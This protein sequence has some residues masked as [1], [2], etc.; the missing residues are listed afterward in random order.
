MPTQAEIIEQLT[1]VIEMRVSQWGE[2][3]PEL[4]RQS[5]DVVLNLTAD[6]DT[7]ADGKIKPT[8]KNIKIIS[9]IKDELNR[10]IFDKRYQDDL[11]HGINTIL[12]QHGSHVDLVVGWEFKPVLTVLSDF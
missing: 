3:M 8:T 11:T 2:R 1:E 6:L 10:V 9:K 7:D 12:H 5:Y 4:Q